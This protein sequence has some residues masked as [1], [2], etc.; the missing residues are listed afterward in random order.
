VRRRNDTAVQQSFKFPVRVSGRY[1]V[2]IELDQW[3][4]EA[5]DP[6][7]RYMLE[8]GRDHSATMCVEVARDR[9]HRVVIRAEALDRF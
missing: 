2:E 3:L 7:R 9:E 5:I 1:Q 8:I 6:I 4:R